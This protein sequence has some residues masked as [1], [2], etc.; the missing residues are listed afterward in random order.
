MKTLLS[1]LAL[2]CVG[3]CK[4][5]HTAW[6]LANAASLSSHTGAASLTITPAADPGDDLE[7]LRTAG[8]VRERAQALMVGHLPG[9]CAVL[10]GAGAPGC[11]ATDPLLLHPLWVVVA[12]CIELGSGG[13][14]PTEVDSV[15]FELLAKALSVEADEQ[16]S[17]A[18][19]G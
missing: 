19:A 9:V 18:G 8:E 7:Q 13:E 17:R 5:L 4:L 1:R 16:R 3:S 10:L 15:M 14:A 2:W 11:F 6:H 12:G